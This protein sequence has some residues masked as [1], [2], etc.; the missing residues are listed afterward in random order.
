[1]S[2]L[3]IC[4][5]CGRVVDIADPRVKHLTQA[6]FAV[7]HSMKTAL[8]NGETIGVTRVAELSCLGV[9]T[10]HYHLTQMRRAGLVS[11]T[12]KRAGG[13][14]KVYGLAA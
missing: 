7:W 4:P 9:S 1:M 3:I 8:K 2:D 5:H 10:A 11:T 12:P 6:T 13:T 14:Y